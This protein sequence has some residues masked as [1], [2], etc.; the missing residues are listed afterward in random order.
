MPMMSNMKRQFCLSL[1]A[2]ENLA[3]VG[4]SWQMLSVTF[5][6]AVMMFLQTTG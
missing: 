5:L 4:S 6:L 2:M 3:S 1:L